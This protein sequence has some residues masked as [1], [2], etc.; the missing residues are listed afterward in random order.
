MQ[1]YHICGRGSNLTITLHCHKRD[2]KS[3]IACMRHCKFYGFQIENN[4]IWMNPLVWKSS[5]SCI[6]LQSLNGILGCLDRFYNLHSKGTK[7]HKDLDLLVHSF[8]GKTPA[9]SNASIISETGK[10]PLGCDKMDG[11]LLQ[12]IWLFELFPVGQSA[13]QL[14]SSLFL[15]HCMHCEKPVM[16]G[17]KL[18]FCFRLCH[19]SAPLPDVTSPIFAHASASRISFAGY[20]HVRPIAGSEGRRQK[21]RQELVVEPRREGLQKVLRQRDFASGPRLDPA[22]NLQV[23]PLGGSTSPS[24]C[25]A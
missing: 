13:T 8:G 1:D 2:P 12:E 17:S 10:T 9:C 20:C 3:Y 21:A 7:G 25:G 23:D 11:H 18:P 16:I 15:T 22:N 24:P 5:V 14:H 19:E 4:R 6:R